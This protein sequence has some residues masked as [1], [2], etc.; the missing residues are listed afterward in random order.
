MISTGLPSEV[1]ATR[2]LEGTNAA[3]TVPTGDFETDGGNV[4]FGPVLIAEGLVA[5]ATRPL[6]FLLIKMG[7]RLTTEVGARCTG[8]RG[9]GR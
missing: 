4:S 3:P 7:L 5:S 8:R 6:L 1:A 9:G 2:R